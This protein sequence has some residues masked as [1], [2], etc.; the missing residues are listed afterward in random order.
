M[1]VSIKHNSLFKYFCDRWKV[2]TCVKCLVISIYVLYILKM[3][4]ELYNTIMV[5]ESRNKTNKILKHFITY[6]T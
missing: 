5:A 3:C 1:F 2:H 6:K 4:F